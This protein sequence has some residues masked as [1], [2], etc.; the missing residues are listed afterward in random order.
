MWGFMTTEPTLSNSEEP[1]QVNSAVSI[2]SDEIIQGHGKRSLQRMSPSGR[3][4][5]S[6]KAWLL[7]FTI[8]SPLIGIISYYILTGIINGNPLTVYSTIMLVY[9]V[10]VLAVGWSSFKSK[11]IPVLD[12]GLVSVIIPIYNQKN[13]IKIVIQ[14]IYASSYKNIEIIA[15]NDGSTDGTKEILDY[16]CKRF[17]NLK[18]I[19]QTNQGKRK[20]V[21]KGF[22]NSKGKFIMLIDSDSVITENAIA[23]IVGAFTSNPKLGAI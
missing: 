23:H 11:I 13:M 10:L 18:V 21:A 17:S 15:V 9:A 6:K 7:R 3:I 8:I 19:H 22:R 1:I 14:A 16:L 5:V 4:Y 2:N 20:A 12:N